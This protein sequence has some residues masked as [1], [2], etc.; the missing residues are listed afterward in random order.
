MQKGKSPQCQHCG[1]L[2]LSHCLL[3]LLQNFYP[4]WDV[5]QKEYCVGLY[6]QQLHPCDPFKTGDHST[7]P[8]HCSMFKAF[9][10]FLLV[11]GQAPIRQE[12]PAV[13]VPDVVSLLVLVKSTLKACCLPQEGHAQ[14]VKDLLLLYRGSGVV[15]L[16]LLQ[17]RHGCVLK[18]LCVVYHHLAA[19]VSCLHNYVQLPA[20][21]ELLLSC[22]QSY[23]G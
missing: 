22:F 20:V 9:H 17:V 23:P 15:M 14:L 13:L 5:C 1:L 11:N 19:S 4:G 7:V 16:N 2:L 21:P 3:F 18:N 6:F 8:L 12:T 10:I